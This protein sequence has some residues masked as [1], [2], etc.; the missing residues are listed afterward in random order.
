MFNRRSDFAAGVRHATLNP[1]G[2]GAARIFLVPPKWR[3]FS[4]A[5]S[6]V[7]L[8]GQWVL[9]V[10]FAWACL[11]GCFLDEINEYRGNPVAPADYDAIIGRAAARCAKAFPLTSRSL[12]RQDLGSMLTVFTDIARG[13]PPSLEIGQLSLRAYARHMTAPHR[14]DLLVSAMQKDGRWN[15]NQRCLHCYAAGQAQAETAELTTE[16]W[17]QAID[18]CRAAGIPQLTFTGGEPTM[19]PDLAELIGH[20]RWFVTR[21]NT[22]GARLDAGLCQALREASLD[23]VQVT[24]YAGEAGIHDRLVGAPGHEKSVQGINN[25]LAAG[26]DVSV[27]T[28]LCSLNSDYRSTLEFLHGLGVRYASCSGL[29]LTGNALAESSAATRLPADA[30]FESLKA[31]KAYADQ[32]GMELAFTSPGWLP[33]E[34]LAELGLQTP[35]CGACLSNMAVAPDGTV[36]PCQSWLSED[37]ALGNMLSDPWSAIW[38]HPKAAAIRAMGEP[39]SLNCPLKAREEAASC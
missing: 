32:S 6:V 2:P 3:P 4:K 30:L 23:S 27:N 37:A 1:E 9:P 15:C 17:K 11:L 7:L 25:A 20:A 16:Q 31:A 5:P 22:N 35:A 18:N 21:L 33:T 34:R 10:R 13:A 12:L 14:M 39:D 36:T 38:N 19:R 29:I 28:P 8:N 26:L 24:L